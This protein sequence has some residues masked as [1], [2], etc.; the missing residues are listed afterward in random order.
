[1][2]NNQEK[3]VQKLSDEILLALGTLTDYDTTDDRR[4]YFK[5]AAADALKNLTKEEVIDI[6][7]FVIVDYELFFD[8]FE[9]S[10]ER[11]KRASQSKS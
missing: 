7:E 1:V 2:N 5:E 6:L 3:A 9:Q 4:K 8:I 10:I 11:S